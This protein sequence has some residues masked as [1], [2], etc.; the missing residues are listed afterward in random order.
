[1]SV[2]EVATGEYHPNPSHPESRQVSQY[3]GF[4]VA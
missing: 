4:A 1:V 2:A 3:H